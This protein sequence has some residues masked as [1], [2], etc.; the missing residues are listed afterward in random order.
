MVN[1]DSKGNP[2]FS[3]SDAIELIY[4][5]KLNYIHNIEFN[6]CN[7]IILFNKFAENNGS[8]KLKIHKEFLGSTEEFDKLNQHLWFIPEEYKKI[9]VKKFII[10]K[11]TSN[12]EIE[13]CTLELNKFEEKNLTNLLRYLIFLVDILR[14]KNILWGVG[15]GSSVSSF[16]LYL[17][18]IHRI[19]PIKFN[20]N[21]QEFLK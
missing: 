12:T 8:N 21:F 9:D 3:V 19:N 15:R 13:R 10:N 5:D 1:L 16:V 4:Q 11:C 18:G 6:E 20:L 14:E 17:I 7:D 2:S